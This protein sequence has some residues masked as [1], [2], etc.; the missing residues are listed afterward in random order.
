MR[1][2]ITSLIEQL[3]KEEAAKIAEAKLDPTKSKLIDKLI[4]VVNI[5][6]EKGVDSDGDPLSFADPKSTWEEPFSYKPVVRKG[7]KV[8]FTDNSPYSNQGKDNVTSETISDDIHAD[9]I[10]GMLRGMVTG[11]KKAYKKAGTSLPFTDVKEG[12]FDFMKK[13]P[14]SSQG[15]VDKAKSEIDKADIGSFW[16]QPADNST[17][18]ENKKLVKII[19]NNLKEKVPTFLKL[20]PEV[21]SDES[22]SSAMFNYNGK[23]IKGIT[24]GGLKAFLAPTTSDV[25]GPKSKESWKKAVDAK[26]GVKEGGV[27][28]AITTIV[29]PDGKTMSQSQKDQVKNAKPGSTIVTKKAGEV[30]TEDASLDEKKKDEDGVDAPVKDAPIEA[31]P[32]EGGSVSSELNNHISSA[33]DAAAK[34]I[35]DSGDKKYEKVLGKV[36]KNLTAAQDALADVQAHETKL[37]EV[38]AAEAEKT[39]ANYSKDLRKVLKKYFKNPD[40]IESVVRKY[41]KVIKQSTDKPVEKIAEMITAH[42][43]KEGLVQK[44]DILK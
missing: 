44:G 9:D 41:G 1:P 23:N 31:A 34:C 11:Y 22:V 39:N 4:K 16:K 10:I 21:A 3:V 33:I 42:A 6:I 14:D 24:L 27:E 25:V 7:N 18:E 29:T 30:V 13:S 35:Q 8:V 28:E 20:F 5:L 32:A 2:E 15:D 12:V 19:K 36:I 26:K 17:N 37:A 38:A 43:L 40:H